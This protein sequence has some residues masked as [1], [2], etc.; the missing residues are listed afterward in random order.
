[1]GIT[2]RCKWEVEREYIGMYEVGR[3]A[4]RHGANNQTVSHRR[5]DGQKKWGS[6]DLL[7]TK[8]KSCCTVL[9]S[10]LKL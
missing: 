2:R 9:Y 1:M 7:D 10:E 3:Q 5:F 6:A 4:G 8:Y